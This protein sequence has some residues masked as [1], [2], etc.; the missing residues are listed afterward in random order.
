MTQADQ[1]ELVGVLRAD[2]RSRIPLT[3][4]GVRPG[5]MYEARVNRTTGEITLVPFPPAATEET[6]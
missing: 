1:S 2:A 6:G 3:K 5:G 4:V